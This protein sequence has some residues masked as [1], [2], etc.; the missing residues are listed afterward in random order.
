MAL[1]NLLDLSTKR[2]K[3][4]LSEERVE[5]IKEY[6]AYVQTKQYAEEVARIAGLETDEK[7]TFDQATY[8]FDCVKI[9]KLDKL[10]KEL[11]RLT[12][13]YNEE[14]DNAKRRDYAMEMTKL[15]KEKNKLS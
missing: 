14:T 6:R 15:L 3:I 11:E 4:G 13:L 1:Q 9:M 8:F 2:K 5:E 12:A 7:K 10:N